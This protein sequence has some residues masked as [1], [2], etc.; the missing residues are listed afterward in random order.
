LAWSVLELIRRN[1]EEYKR[2]LIR[3]QQDPSLADKFYKIDLE[4]R[5][6][7]VKLNE[8]RHKHNMISR[9]IGKTRDPAERKRLVEEARSLLSELKKL[10]EEFERLNRE[11]GELLFQLPNLVAEEVPEGGEEDSLPV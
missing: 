4:W 1:P 2:H 6:I 9:S 3:R 5:Q 8:L 11:R 10:E 7:Q